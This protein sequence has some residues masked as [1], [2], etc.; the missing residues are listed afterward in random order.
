MCVGMGQGAAGI[1]ERSD[2]RR[3]SCRAMHAASAPRSHAAPQGS[4]RTR[5]HDAPLRRGHGARASGARRAL[6]GPRPA[7]PTATWSARSAASRRRRRCRRCCSIPQRLGDA[8]RAHGQFRGG[9]GRR[10]RSTSRRAAGAHQPLDPAL[11]VRDPAGRADGG[12]MTPRP[13]WSRRC[14]ATPGAATTRRCPQVPRPP[15][16][17]ACARPGQRVEWVNRYEMRFIERRHSRRLGRAASHAQPHPPV[18]ARRA[19]APARLRLAH[20][21]GRRVLPARL[22]APRHAA[23]RSAR[24][25]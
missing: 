14:A 7:P 11:D 8:G 3:A 5:E 15:T 6:H 12:R 21:A 10:R 18:G 2:A 24:C 19:A 17:R 22:A 13:P 16:S 9:A 25:R 4:T 20:G 1:F 23:C